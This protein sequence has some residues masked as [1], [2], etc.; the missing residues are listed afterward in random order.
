VY[1]WA[2][3][4]EPFAGSSARPLILGNIRPVYTTDIFG[5]INHIIH[6]DE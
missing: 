3:P 2:S 4:S 1:T 5:V 6:Q